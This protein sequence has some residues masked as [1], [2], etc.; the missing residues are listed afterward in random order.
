MKEGG[1]IAT[2]FTIYPNEEN[3][4]ENFKGEPEEEEEEEGARLC[5]VA[6]YFTLGGLFQLKP[7]LFSQVK[8]HCRD[9]IINI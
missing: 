6:Y 5:P 1:I 9:Q 2:S 8:N 4:R 3:G 7:M